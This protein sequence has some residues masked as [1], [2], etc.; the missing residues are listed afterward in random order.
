MPMKQNDQN[1]RRNS[2]EA[3]EAQDADDA[4]LTHSKWIAERFERMNEQLLT[5]S[6]TFIGFLVIELGLLA[7]FDPTRFICHLN[8]KIVGILALISLVAAI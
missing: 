8:D 2:K 1:P 5:L 7:Q 4:L 6:A 3:I